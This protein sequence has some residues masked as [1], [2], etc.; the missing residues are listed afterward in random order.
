V[1]SCCC[2]APQKRLQLRLAARPQGRPRR[3]ARGCRAWRRAWEAHQ[4]RQ[5]REIVLVLSVVGLAFLCSLPVR[6]CD[7]AQPCA[8]FISL[9]FFPTADGSLLPWSALPAGAPGA[10]AVPPGA[11]G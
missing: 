11:P 2:T 10:E 1:M 7:C 6:L 8:S 9:A 5:A 3:V 4:T